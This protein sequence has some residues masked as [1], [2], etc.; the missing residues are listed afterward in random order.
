M[1]AARR[2]DHVDVY[3]G[4]EVPDPYRWLEDLDSEETRAWVAA[5]NGATA[6][7]LDAVEE[8]AAIRARLEAVWDHERW[9]VPWKEGGRIFQ[10]RND[11]LEDQDVL[12]VREGPDGD[13]RVLL[14]PN[15]LSDDGT[16]AVAGTVV[17]HDGRRLAYG[18][19]RS[20]SDWT[21]W[22]VRDVDTG[23]DLPDRIEWSKFSV[24]A[25]AHDASG[26]YYAGY[27]APADGDL[28]EATNYFQKLY[29]H[30]LGTEQADDVLVLD[31]PEHKEWGFA[32]RVTRDGRYLVAQVWRGS[33]SMHLI[34]VR[35]LR[36]PAAGFQPLVEDWVAEFEPLGNVGTTLYFRTNLNAP[37]Y[38]VVACDLARDPAPRRASWREIVPEQSGTLASASLVGDGLVGVVLEDARSRVR[39]FDREGAFVR[40]VD[41]PGIGTVAGFEGSLDD[42]ETWFSFTSFLRPAE[43][44]RYDVKTGATTL[45]QRPTLA[46]DADAFETRQ[47]FFASKDGT[48]IPMFLTHRKGLT[49]DGTHPTYLYGYGGFNTALTPSFAPSV[50]AWMEMG[51][52]F[53]VANLRGGGEYGHEWYRAG[54]KA[55]KQNVFD[56][57]IA[58]AEW[59]IDNDY[60]STP[61]LAIG[62]GSNGG[63]LVGACM[64][65]RPDLYGAC[66]PAVGVLDMLRFHKFTIG[67]AWVS[68]YGCSDDPADFETLLA[69]SPLHNLREGVCYPPTLVVTSDHD[70]RVVPSHSYKFAAELQ[71][72]QACEAPVLIR[73]DVKAGHGLGTPTSK[74]LD[75]AA[76]R[77]AFLVRTLDM[78]LAPGAVAR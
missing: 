77:W 4:H 57:F 17:S 38:R 46:A 25:W 68:D 27:D 65:Q 41:L 62:G 58:A 45:V 53:A 10:A 69:Y 30:R 23:T 61:R 28:Y 26:F 37:R 64:T 24:A 15:T 2:S 47:V 32:P 51:G 55:E 14:D 21:E 7:F 35:D 63:L 9:G 66:I 71:H 48:R 20:G 42:P 60:T 76:D 13:V 6:A 36:D 3:H 72:V 19:R 40:N 33:G 39:V 5:Q 49:L 18:V 54:T 43:I 78:E 73:I 67:W 75:A 11:G 59:L 50:L 44:Y 52:I 56:D 29:F 12:T 74:L 16:V 8:R 34:Y 22:R 1:K 31:D 70:D